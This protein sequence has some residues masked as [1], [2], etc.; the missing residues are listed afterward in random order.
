M[1]KFL[2]IVG[3]ILGGI[4]AIA[5]IVLGVAYAIGFAYG[6]F[7]QPSQVVAVSTSVC[8]DGDIDTYNKIVLTFPTNN[9]DQAKKVASFKSLADEVKKKAD[10]AKDPTCVF[11]VYSAAI[12]SQDAVE[13][14]T[15]YDEAVT[16]SEAGNYPKNT[17]LDIVSLQSMKDRVESLKNTESGEQ[18]PLGSG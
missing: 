9:D 7:K 13:A 11:I 16:L 14:K 2:K 17:L 6:G 5:V 3:L 15:Q 18:N 10:Y 1:K 4:V 8:S 12:Q